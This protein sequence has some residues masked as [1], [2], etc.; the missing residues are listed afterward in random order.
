MTHR[1][2]RHGSRNEAAPVVWFDG[3]I[4]NEVMLIVA[5]E[6]LLPLRIQRLQQCLR[7]RMLLDDGKARLLKRSHKHLTRLRMSEINGLHLHD[8]N[9]ESASG[10]AAAAAPFGEVQEACEAAYPRLASSKTITSAR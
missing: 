10:L 7:H 8:A 2:L 3:F 1:R 4:D 5:Q 6:E 9:P